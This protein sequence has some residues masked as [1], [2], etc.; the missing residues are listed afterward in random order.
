[1]SSAPS[2]IEI[3]FHKENAIIKWKVLNI[4]GLGPQ[5]L[6]I[7][8]KSSVSWGNP[9]ILLSTIREYLVSGLK[10][11]TQYE[12]RIE[13]FGY[14]GSDTISGIT[15]S[16]MNFKFGLS[17]HPMWSEES[18]NNTKLL[19]STSNIKG[20]IIRFDIGWVNIINES[21][22]YL[23]RLDSFISECISHN[24]LPLPCLMSPPNGKSALNT[25][26]FAQVAGQVANRYK[27]KL[28]GIEI[29]NE[30]NQNNVT[31]TEYTLLCK[32]AY[33]AIKAV[34]P[35]CLIVAGA[36]A[37][38]NV[39]YLEECYAA[40]LKG[41]FDRLS[42]HPYC[43]DLP[44][45]EINTKAPTP[46][47][48]FQGGI[49]A[50]R[51]VQLAAG[52]ESPVILTEFGYSTCAVNSEKPWLSGVTEEVQGKYLVEAISIAE[53]LDYINGI[54]IYEAKDAASPTS[55]IDVLNSH[56]GIYKNNWEPKLAV[57]Y[58]KNR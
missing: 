5:Y 40:G 22:E 37:E 50:M 45:G 11:N 26:E 49:E 51:N 48:E 8:K 32:A 55:E 16:N 7:K 1:M 21:K 23:S 56:Y 29:W 54:C 43:W 14:T 44:P 53:K 41:N 24:I 42:Y 27:G 39:A 12:F 35:G 38:T 17:A 19:E 31:P 2:N 36:I 18:I 13:T 34:D 58:L 57:S 4:I 9:I 46:L 33:P 3:I 52:D 6:Y 47:A 28:Y 20:N 10:E 25:S 30:P 15:G